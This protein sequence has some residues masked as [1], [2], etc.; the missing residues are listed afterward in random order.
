[1]ARITSNQIHG[2]SV[3]TESGAHLG[4]VRN[5]EV[6]VESHTVISYT[7]K[8]L[9]LA[10]II[11]RQDLLIHPA[12]VVAITETQMTVRDTTTPLAESRGANLPTL[13]KNPLPALSSER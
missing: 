13:K 8:P 7:V 4:H 10:A 11:G 3:M 12:N 2:L 5:F 9:G 1:M 6:D